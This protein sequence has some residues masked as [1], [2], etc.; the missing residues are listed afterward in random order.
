MCA[1]DYLCTK[2]IQ[3][4]GQSCQDAIWKKKTAAC[5]WLGSVHS[6]C[7]R[8]QGPF[9]RQLKG[10]LA[11]SCVL[12]L[13][14]S[15]R[16]HFSL[17]YWISADCFCW[18]CVLQSSSSNSTSRHLLRKRSRPRN[19]PKLFWDP[20]QW[21]AWGPISVISETL[22]IRCCAG[23][24]FRLGSRCSLS[25]HPDHCTPWRSDVNS[26][27][28]LRAN[29]NEPNLLMAWIHVNPWLTQVS[30][31]WR[32]ANTWPKPA[33]RSTLTGLVSDEHIAAVNCPAVIT[34]DAAA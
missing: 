17:A 13:L 6:S 24:F 32:L 8:A 9:R 34:V 30:G 12:L 31:W 28:S 15:Y 22:N 11:S 29:A 26:V 18:C 3:T 19:F 23:R 10:A 21:V 5:L 20:D 7:I 2:K 16:Q 33:P 1:I 14:P 27:W 4:R 25:V